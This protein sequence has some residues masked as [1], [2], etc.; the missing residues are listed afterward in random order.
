M[1]GNLSNN[2]LFNAT[3]CTL[4][5][6]VL[7]LALLRGSHVCPHQILL[8]QLVHRRHDPGLEGALL[9]KHP[10]RLSRFVLG[11]ILARVDDGVVV[12][13][14]VHD[15]VVGVERSWNQEKQSLWAEIRNHHLNPKNQTHDHRRWRSACP[16]AGH[17][18]ESWQTPGP[19]NSSAWCWATVRSSSPPWWNRS[20]WAWVWRSRSRSP[21]QSAG[22]SAGSRTTCRRR[23]G[24]RYKFG[25]VFTKGQKKL[26]ELLNL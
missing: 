21:A 20:S 8:H 26:P 3:E 22:R 7:W 10:S 5:P 23:T 11:K 14:G 15:P 9:G 2:S 13:V 24:G 25:F 19:P 18:P 16:P 6:Y 1:L 12:V 17:G 4:L